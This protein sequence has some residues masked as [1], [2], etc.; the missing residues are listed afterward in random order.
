[1]GFDLMLACFAA[2]MTTAMVKLR[3]D[4]V[5]LGVGAGAALVLAQLFGPAP[6][7]IGAGLAG[8]AVAALLHRGAG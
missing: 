7:I 1:L 2:G 8:A 4:L 5:P 3:A 6:A